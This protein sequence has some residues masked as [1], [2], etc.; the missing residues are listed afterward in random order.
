MEITPNGVLGPHV[1][2]RV[3]LEAAHVLALA[4]ILPSVF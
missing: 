1:R 2:Y 4:Q 3:G